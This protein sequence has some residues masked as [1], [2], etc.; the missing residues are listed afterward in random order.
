MAHNDY[1]DTELVNVLKLLDKHKSHEV[2]AMLE[3]A[4]S[5]VRSMK[6]AALARGLTVDSKP[7]ESLI[8]ENKILK[9]ALAEARR[10]TDSAARI[11]E[12]IY[13]LAA[14]T[15][16]PPTWLT[17]PGKAGF[18]GTPFL[19]C[20]D[21]HFGEVV[22]PEEVGGVNE[23][24]TEIAKARA[25]RLFETTVDLAYNHMGRAKIEYPGI[26]CALGGDMLTGEIHPELADTNDRKPFETLNDLE[27]VLIPGIT[28]LADKFGAVYVPCVVGNHGRNTLKKRTKTT[29]HT[30]YEWHLYVALEKHF[31]RVGDKRVTF[32][33]PDE[34]DVYFKSY[35]HRYLLTHGDNLGVKGGDGMIGAIGPITRG[36]I[37]T[38]RSEAQIGRDFDTVVMGHWHQRLIGPNNS[39]IVN[40]S[41]KGYDEFARLILRAPYTR[42]SQSLWFTHPEHGITAHWEVYLEGL[43]TANENMKWLEVQRAG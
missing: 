10:F 17:K 38:G 7:K 3:K 12:E 31:R 13:E 33:I 29:V 24:N 15:P 16:S 21:W 40:N 6:G 43:R 20:S 18:R 19:M 30:S 4:P 41:L 23:F 36:S 22:K 8:N 11:R 37:K 9:A 27:E 5:T 1:T 42:P 25:K 32:D 14:H 35:G 26:I 2:A 34:T 28:L 39:Y